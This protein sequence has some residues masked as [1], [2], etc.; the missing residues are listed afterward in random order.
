MTFNR[1]HYCTI[2]NQ[3]LPLAKVIVASL[4]KVAAAWKFLMTGAVIVASAG[5]M[6]KAFQSRVSLIVVSTGDQPAMAIKRTITG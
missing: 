5:F 1:Y 4:V 6:P 2:S 3:P